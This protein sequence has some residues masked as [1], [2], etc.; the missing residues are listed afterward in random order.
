MKRKRRTRPQPP[1]ETQLTLTCCSGIKLAKAT[2]P[3]PP[4]P[5]PKPKPPPPAPRPRPRPAATA[6]IVALAAFTL[7][8]CWTSALRATPPPKPNAP[9]EAAAD[10]RARSTFRDRIKLRR[11]TRLDR[12]RHSRDRLRELLPR[13][14]RQHDAPA[15]ADDLEQ[16]RPQPPEHGF[17]AFLL[18]IWTRPG[19]DERGRRATPIAPLRRARPARTDAADDQPPP[20]ELAPLAPRSQPFRR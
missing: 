9:N 12:R 11:E 13:S 16:D 15:P 7:C 18:R 17:R 14:R 1:P 8:C 4:P 6:P 5:H 2:E 19:A 10:E 3:P 20:D